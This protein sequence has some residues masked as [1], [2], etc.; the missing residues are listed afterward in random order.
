MPTWSNC[1]G[2]GIGLGLLLPNRF[3]F[4]LAPSQS[5]GVMGISWCGSDGWVQ[6]TAFILFGESELGGSG[7]PA[8]SDPN[9]NGRLMPL[10]ILLMLNFHTVCAF[11]Q[12]T[13][14]HFWW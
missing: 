10:L 12:W 6:N 3:S 14:C 7:G 1:A 11:L 8:D 9:S 13:K 5:S 2:R 4:L